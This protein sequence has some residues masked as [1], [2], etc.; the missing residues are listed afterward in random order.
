MRQDKASLP[1]GNEN[2]LQR[3]IRVL[4]SAVP[5]VVIVGAMGQSPPEH[6]SDVRW[7]NDSAQGNGPLQGM[8]DGFDALA[9][10]R[11]PCLVV[12]CDMPFLDQPLVEHLFQSLGNADGVV[13]VSEGRPHP[14][15][16]VYVPQRVR[17]KAIAMLADGQRKLLLLLEQLNVRYV[18]CPESMAR[19]FR[20][21]NTPEDYS[22]A[23][24]EAGLGA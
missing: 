4:R 9:E 6:L 14:L 21:V 16:A 20:N 8:V 10:P 13:P 18:E 23:R 2:L 5:T 7:V 3:T 24:A 15:S 17:S 19:S 11:N 12:A 1:F 22:A